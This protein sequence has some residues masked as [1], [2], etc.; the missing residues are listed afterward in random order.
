MLII[1][2]HQSFTG[3]LENLIEPCILP[4]VELEI[5]AHLSHQSGTRKAS[6]TSRLK[7]S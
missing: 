1:F 2:I 4:P 6:L 5:I 3:H 7:A